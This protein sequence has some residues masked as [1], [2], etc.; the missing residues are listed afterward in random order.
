MPAIRTDLCKG[1]PILPISIMSALTLDTMARGH[2]EYQPSDIDKLPH[3]VAIVYEK[4]LK[5]KRKN[6]GEPHAHPPLS[7]AARSVLDIRADAVNLQFTA[8]Q[9]LNNEL[10]R[11]L[12]GRRGIWKLI[13]RA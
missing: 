3:Y 11:R 4:M 9:E 7:L 8:A 6:M 2:G 1:K 5:V 10:N 13:S 12:K